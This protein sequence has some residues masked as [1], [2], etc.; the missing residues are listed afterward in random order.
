M[1]VSLFVATLAL[2]AVNLA[3]HANPLN[4]SLTGTMSGTLGATAF[5]DATVTF[6]FLADTANTTSDGVGDFTN[7]TGTGTVTIN[8]L[9]TAAFLSSTFGVL[10]SFESAGFFDTGFNV[11]IL[12]FAL[13]SYDLTAPFTDTSYFVDGFTGVTGPEATSLGDLVI[14]D[15]AFQDPT[16]TTFTASAAG[17]VIPEPSS[18][19]LLGTGLVGLVGAAR[20]RL[21]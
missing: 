20:R 21:A 10:G 19:M 6:N 7:N 8:G 2:C 16:G 11:G 1:R 15:G 17:S 4:Y 14:N 3:A 18:F 12:D 9:G 13:A 5:T